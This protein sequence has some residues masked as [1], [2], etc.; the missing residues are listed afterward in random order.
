MKLFRMIFL[1]FRFL[2]QKIRNDTT[3]WAARGCIL[4]TLDS[5]K[6]YRE[7][8]VGKFIISLNRDVY[9]NYFSFYFYSDNDE[10]YDQLVTALLHFLPKVE[11]KLIKSQFTSLLQIA[12]MSKE[13]PVHNESLRQAQRFPNNVFFTEQ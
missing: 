12:M 11:E 13:G 4:P 7:H 3:P 5:L 8:I 1:D 10:S 2:D 6:F 9:K